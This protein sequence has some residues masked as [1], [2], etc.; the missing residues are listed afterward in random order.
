MM[1]HPL[2]WQ[3]LALLETFWCDALVREV[4]LAELPNDLCF[5]IT[6]HRMP[7]HVKDT[8]PLIASYLPR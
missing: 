7:A 1:L 6:Y 4:R 5:Y 8:R 2:L 3:L